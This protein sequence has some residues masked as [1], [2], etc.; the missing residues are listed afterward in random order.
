MAQIPLI[1]KR[2]AGRA[3]LVSDE[4]QVE[5]GVLN[6]AVKKFPGGYEQ[7]IRNGRHGWKVSLA[8]M[9][10]SQ[11]VQRELFSYEHVHHKNHDTLDNRDEN[12]LLLTKGEHI[13]EHNR[14]NRSYERAEKAATEKARSNPNAGAYQNRNGTWSAYFL[15]TYLGRFQT[16]EEAVACYRRA[17]EVGVDAAR[18]S[19]RPKNRTA[20]S[21]AYLQKSG[22]WRAQF[23]A[24]SLGL[25]D[26]K[27]EAI[28]AYR[29]AVEE[30]VAAVRKLERTPDDPNRGV[31]LTPSGRWSASYNKKYLGRYDT[32]EEARAAYLAE[33]AAHEESRRRELGTV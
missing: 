5:L 4:R 2:G 27:E 3:T 28:T 31:L 24:Q 1:G 10:M 29:K 12:L 11:M 33:R 20:D 14:E 17:I 26:T 16:Q 30:G 7:V 9:I 8:R 23:R 18:V 32:K 25:Y 15:G 19:T 22:R 13:A 6:W 21:G